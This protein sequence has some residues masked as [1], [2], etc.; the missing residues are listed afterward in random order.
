MCPGFSRVRREIEPRWVSEYVSNTYAQYKHAYRVPL[1]SIPEEITKI[2]GATKGRRVYRPS[3]PEVDAMIWTNKFLVLLEGKIF[4]I[5]DGIAKL[6]VYKSL[7]PVTPELEEWRG[8]PIRMELLCVQP[9]PW[10]QEAAD[11]AGVNVIK[12][13]PRWIQEIWQERDKYWTPEAVE[14]REERKKVLRSLGFD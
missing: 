8:T 5:M 1:G 11:R 7:V 3:R 4:K 2:Y 13:A 14:K 6:P 9:L 10:V 12:W